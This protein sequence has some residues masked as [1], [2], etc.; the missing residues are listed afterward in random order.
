MKEIENERKILGTEHG[1]S[2]SSEKSDP[3]KSVEIRILIMA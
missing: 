1:F 2:R 3:Q